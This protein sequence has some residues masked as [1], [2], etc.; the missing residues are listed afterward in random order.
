MWGFRTST[1]M[2]VFVDALGQA[3]FIAHSQQERIFPGVESGVRIGASVR[4][5]RI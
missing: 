5:N 1:L 4:E 3:G 2:G